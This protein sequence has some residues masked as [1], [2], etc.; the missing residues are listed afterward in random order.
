MHSKLAVETKTIA[1][2]CERRTAPISRITVHHTAGVVSTAEH[3]E[4]VIKMWNTDVVNKPSANYLITNDGTVYCIIEDEYRS[5]ASSSFENDN[6]A[7]TIEVS[8][9]HAGG[10]WPVSKAAMDALI[11]LM[12]DLCATYGI[13]LKYTGNKNGSL[14]VH[15]MFAATSCPGPYL[16]DAIPGIITAVDLMLSNVSVSL[17]PWQVEK[18]K[19]VEHCILEGYI[20]GDGTRE[21]WDSFITKSELAVVLYRMYNKSAEADYS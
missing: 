11:S 9:S 13:K 12:A 3:V 2:H 15:Q 18:D 4:R 14:T 19:A 16:L 5:Q 8:N 20:K 7:I 17:P 21:D 6:S 10:T 1:I